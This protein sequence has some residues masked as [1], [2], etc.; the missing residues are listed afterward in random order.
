MGYKHIPDT[1]DTTQVSILISVAVGAKVDRNKIVDAVAHVGTFAL[2]QILPF[3]EP[4]L[5]V[6]PPALRST[7]PNAEG[8]QLS[9]AFCAEHL[10]TLLEKLV[11][12]EPKTVAAAALPT[13]LNLPIEY[14]VIL[15][16]VVQQIINK[17]ISDN[18]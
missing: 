3:A 6:V 18:K 4:P 15:W 16:Q 10:E 17:I 2:G 7:V 11:E 9:D 14:Y 5:P 8:K 1:L 13:A 12:A